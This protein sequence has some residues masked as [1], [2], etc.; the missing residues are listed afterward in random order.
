MSEGHGLPQE[1]ACDVV[2]RRALDI[3]ETGNHL[4]FESTTGSLWTTEDQGDAWRCV[5]A[6]LPPISSVRFVK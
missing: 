3:D 6:N 2:Y 1:H 4:A 5:S